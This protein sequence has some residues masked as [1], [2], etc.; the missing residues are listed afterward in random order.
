[1][2]S[3]DKGLA[4]LF[5]RSSTDGATQDATAALENLYAGTEP[6]ACWL[7]GSGPSLLDAD[8]DAIAGSP[9]P[10]IGV[11]FSGRGPDGTPPLLTPDIWTSYDPTARF[12]RS[13]FLNPRIMKFLKSDKDKNLVPG[14]NFKAC[15]CPATYFFHNECR[16]YSDFL[17]P[18]S[19]AILN[20]KDS[21]V[22]ALDIGFRLGFRIFYCVGTDMVIRPSAGQVRLA[23]SVGMTYDPNKGT[24]IKRDNVRDVWSDRLPD[25]V[26]EY[27]R[28]RNG[29]ERAKAIEELE[30]PARE[31]QYSFTE[32]KPLAAALHSDSHY[33]ERVQYLRLSRRCLSINGV[34]LVSCTPGSR[35]NAWF[36]TSTVAEACEAIRKSVGCPASEKTKGKYSGDVDLSLGLPV[37]KDVM[38]YS[39]PPKHLMAKPKA[40]LQQDAKDPAVVQ[41]AIAEPIVA[42]PVDQGDL[43]IEKFKGIASRAGDAGVEVQEVF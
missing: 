8:I 12:H 4:M 14:T 31:S 6:T 39:W 43:L 26:D 20:A 29:L 18:G 2:W 13:I 24:L 33:W 38:P 9:A 27:V 17:R 7:V 15:D 32:R 35:L 19:N 28:A 25:F 3:G 41:E 30:T 5:F 40:P 10:K 23:E 1:M 22:Q 36:R 34:S 21:F 16:G 37:H 42:H 11:N